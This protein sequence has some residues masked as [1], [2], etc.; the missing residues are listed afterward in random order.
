MKRR[1]P[2][3]KKLVPPTPAEFRAQARQAFA[4]LARE[5]GFREEAI[6]A[7]LHNP[8]AVWFVN[9][10]TRVVIEGINYGVNARV[11]IGRCGQPDEFE[12]NDLH[13]LATVCRPTLALNEE[14]MRAEEQGGQWVQLPRMAA[15][16]RE[17]G[18]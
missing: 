8:V 9:E 7:G 13:D 12:N 11:A 2:H 16:L 10:T 1:I 15:W 5:F 4:F 14:Q 6:P 18:T 17:C 3:D